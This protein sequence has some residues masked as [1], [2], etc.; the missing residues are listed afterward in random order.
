MPVQDVALLFGGA[1]RPPATTAAVT[2][3]LN[4]SQGTPPISVSGSVVLRPVGGSPIDSR[5]FSD[6]IST[7]PPVQR[8]Y[9][10]SFDVRN[11]SPGTY[12]VFAQALLSNQAGGRTLTG[13]AQFTIQP[14]AVPPDGTIQVTV[15]LQ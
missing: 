15:T 4:V 13:S 1:V 6:T 3:V 9:Q 11:L 5:S 10:L 12:E 7:N 2:V 14:P 8:T